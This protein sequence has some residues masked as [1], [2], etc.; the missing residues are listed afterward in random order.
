MKHI[1]YEEWKLEKGESFKRKKELSER[2]ILVFFHKRI[3]K[4]YV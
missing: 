4:L 3:H 2:G 1:G